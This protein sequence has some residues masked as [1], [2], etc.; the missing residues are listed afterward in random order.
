MS[1]LPDAADEFSGL[2]RDLSE[3][4][5]AIAMY[6]EAA[7]RLAAK[8]APCDDSQL[9]AILGKTSAQ[10]DLAGDLLRRLRDLA[11]ESRQ[12]PA[13][14]GVAFVQPAQEPTAGD[15]TEPVAR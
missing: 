14:T 6:V 12:N 5:T 7:R 15:D 8:H 4:L 10:A 9:K 11:A 13:P 2:V 1:D 3:R